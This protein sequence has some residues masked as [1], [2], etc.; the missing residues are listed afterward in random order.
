MTNIEKYGFSQ[1][2]KLYLDELDATLYEFSHIKSDARLI[3]LDR[4]DENK[5]FAIGFATPPSDD[6]GVFHIIE[7]SVLCG[8]EKYPLNDPFAELLK[9]SLNTF[10]NAITYED[11]TV[12]PVSSRC[13]KD[14]LNLVDVYMDAVFA[15]NMLHN[16]SI[17][18][19]EGWH[20]EYDGESNSLSYNG[21]VYNEM[22]GAYS[23]PDELGGCV[24]RQQLFPNSPYSKDSGGIPAAIPE[25]TYEQFKAAHQKYYHP[26]NARIVLDG[27]ID[28]DK[29]LP[30]LD[31]HLSK[32]DKQQRVCLEGKSEPVIAPTVEI[33]YEISET[34]DEHGRARV[35]Y[36]YVFADHTDREAS[37]ATSILSDILC[38][39]NASPLKKAILDKGLAK[40]VEM[41][42][43]KSKDLTLNIEVR[44]ADEGRLNEID[45]VINEVIGELVTGGIDKKKILSSLNFIEFKNRE[46]DFGSL[47]TGIV[48]ALS[49]YGEWMYSDAPEQ[50]LIM[51]DIFTS[52]RSKID[53]D[54][55]EKLLDLAFIK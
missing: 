48:L 47:P 14:F 37:I 5:T 18:R 40:N 16:P 6:T 9:G 36:G 55:F 44:D 12:Y 17:F 29:I 50:A 15:P 23:S 42:V 25:L 13:E 19:Q 28:M 39:S 24:L 38:G 22:K 33:K 2:R 26:T 1:V 46:R 7:H 32:F 30:M 3:Y 43:S 41:Y 34:E 11:R 51:D 21:V 10:L 45:E 52:I 27:R 20:Y 35:L 8:S 31:A 53:S 54:Y 4:E 49:L